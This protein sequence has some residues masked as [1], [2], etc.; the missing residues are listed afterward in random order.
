MRVRVRI[1]ANPRKR[2]VQEDSCPVA[3]PPA[4]PRHLPARKPT[5]MPRGLARLWNAI[6]PPPAAVRESDGVSEETKRRR[7]KLGLATAA[8]VVVVGG[9]WGAYLYVASAPT[10]AD[11]A[12]QQGMLRMGAGDYKGAVERF[13]K[14]VDIWP[15]MANGYFERGLALRSMNQPDAAIEDFE[16]AI[17]KDSSMAPAHT[18]LGSIYRER[19]DLTRAMNE[20]GLS[21]QLNTS[22]EAF[23]ERGQVH[24]SLGQHQQAIEDYGAAIHEQPDS[25]YVYRARAMSLEALGDHDGAA[26]DRRTAILI[27]RS[28]HRR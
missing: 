7:R 27:E 19:G 15:R 1:L 4:V 16:R 9:A 18:A 17:G 22:T 6:K 26:Q 3:T 24:E 11:A 28:F 21:L 10:R 14:A 13:T 12:F 20:F 8:V 5:V 25:P 23:Y 2:V